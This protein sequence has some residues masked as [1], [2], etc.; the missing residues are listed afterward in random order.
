MPGELNVDVL[1]DRER[2]DGAFALL[3][4]SAAEGSGPPEHIHDDQDEAL[5]VLEGGLTV[6]IDGDRQQA[7]PGRVVFIPRGSRHAYR[8]VTPHARFLA[9]LTPPGY[10]GP[11]MSVRIP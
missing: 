9:I 4:V 5:L 1:A 3:D 6:T 11:V 7:A 10:G 2:T 8:V